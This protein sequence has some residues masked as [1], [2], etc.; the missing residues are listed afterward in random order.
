VAFGGPHHPKKRESGCIAPDRPSFF[1]D[2]LQY[3]AMGAAGGGGN[4]QFFYFT[5]LMAWLLQK[6]GKRFAAPEQHDDPNAT[7]SSVLQV[8][9][10]PCFGYFASKADP[11]RPQD[12]VLKC[13]GWASTFSRGVWAGDALLVPPAFETRQITLLV[14]VL[15]TLKDMGFAA[16]SF[17]PAKLK[18]GWGDAVR[19]PPPP[20][21]FSIQ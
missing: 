6:A 13:T 10:A 15:Q 18:Q 7:C 1:H 12:W 3:F 9:R 16:P 8:R 14:D 17:P 4:D 20:C 19:A 21:G 11:W 5:S 2:A